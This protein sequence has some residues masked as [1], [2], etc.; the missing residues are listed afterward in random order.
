ME[1]L[2]AFP[3]ESVDASTLSLETRIALLARTLWEDYGRPDD[4]DVAIWMEAE[5]RVLRVLESVSEMAFGA[6]PAFSRRTSS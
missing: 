5:R 4:C 3:V 2:P 1:S 6:P